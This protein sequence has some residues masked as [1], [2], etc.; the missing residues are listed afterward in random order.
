[1]IGGVAL[2][3]IGVGV[4]KGDIGAIMGMAGLFSTIGGLYLAF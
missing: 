1:M 2:A 4:V 3:G